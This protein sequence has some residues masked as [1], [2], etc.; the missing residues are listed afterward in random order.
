MDGRE[1]SLRKNM[2]RSIFLIFLSHKTEHSIFVDDHCADLCHHIFSQLQICT[3][4]IYFVAE[5]HFSKGET[6][7]NHMS[8][9]VCCAKYRS[10]AEKSIS[11][12]RALDSIL[13]GRETY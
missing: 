6:F 12:A 11:E 2:V 13:Q 1:W 4:E 9:V 7:Q 5:N 10:K 8:H 3:W